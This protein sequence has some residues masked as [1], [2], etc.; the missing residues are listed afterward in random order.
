MITPD[1]RCVL[2]LHSQ[3]FK[4]SF[5]FVKVKVK[6][7]DPGV[8]KTW[9]K[10]CI[11]DLG[12]PCCDLSYVF[13]TDEELC[14]MNLKYLSHDTLTDII[15]FDFNEKNSLSGEMYISVDRVNEN[16]LKFK[17]NPSEELRRVM[18]HGVLHL[19][20]YGDKTKGEKI[21]MRKLEN[22]YLSL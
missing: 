5:N 13:V 4:I 1:Q 20:G 6:S 17:V 15:T 19:A 2:H 16:A 22:K 9:I 11:V 18:I 7:F 3:M 12:Y 21:R 8:K 10:N 14:E